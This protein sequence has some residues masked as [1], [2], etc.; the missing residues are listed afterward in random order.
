[1]WSL[2]ETYKRAIWILIISQFCSNRVG[3]IGNWL[4]GDFVTM[5]TAVPSQQILDRSS[6][7]AYPEIRELEGQYAF[8]YTY[9]R[10]S[11]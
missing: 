4:P 8:P 5:Q 2:V 1:M 7:A 11:T 6:D 9:H 3:N 10:I